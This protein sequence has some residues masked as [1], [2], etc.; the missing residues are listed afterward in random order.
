MATQ[1][2]AG[3]RTRRRRG[4]RARA[5]VDGD[6]PCIGC[7][8]VVAADG[9]H[10]TMGESAGLGIEDLGAPMDVL[11]FRL[12]RDPPRQARRPAATF[13]RGLFLV[14]INRDSYWQCGYVI[15]KG[16]LECA[17]GSGPGCAQSARS[18]NAAP[19]LQD[20]LATCKDW[21]DLKLLT[22]QVSRMPRWY[23]DGLLC[24]GDAAHAMSP[25]GGVGHQPGDPGRGCRR[26]SACAIRLR[27]KRPLEADLAALQRR[28]DWPTRV[29]QRMQIAV[30]NEVLLPCWPAGR[31]R[32]E[33]LIA[34]PSAAI[35]APAADAEPDSG[36]PGRHWRA[37]GARS[38]GSSGGRA[39]LSSRLTARS[40]GK[41]R[42][43]HS[44]TAAPE[45]SADI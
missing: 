25:V 24:I 27:E 33:H 10:T 42:P 21:E 44:I 26:Q 5:V 13:G 39:S 14:T 15:A 38:R 41:T 2:T 40:A 9:R 23:R 1:A 8:L 4:G 19:F 37:A 3:H 7:D 18:W 30:Q 32:S 22:V 35:A 31:E 20:S 34:A 16:S 45:L 12:P 36:A 6:R 43:D 11:W 28:R 29:T 17:T